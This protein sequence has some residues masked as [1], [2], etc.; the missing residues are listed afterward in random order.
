VCHPEEE[1]AIIKQETLLKNQREGVEEGAT[2]V[3]S[4]KE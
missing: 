3:S 4:K 2:G 1:G